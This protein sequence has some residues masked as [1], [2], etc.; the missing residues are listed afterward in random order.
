MT[1]HILR[2]VNSKGEQTAVGFEIDYHKNYEENYSDISELLEWPVE[3]M[4]HYHD[5]EK[6]GGMK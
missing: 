1:I 5:D 6:K 4:K 3:V 2:K